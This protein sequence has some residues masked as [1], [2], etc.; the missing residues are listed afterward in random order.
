M[1]TLHCKECGA[2]LKI[3]GKKTVVCCE[4]C[5]IENTLPKMEDDKKLQRIERANQL[6]RS[7][8]FDKAAALYEEILNEDTTDAEIYWSLVLCRYGIEYVVDPYSQKHMP[9]VNRAQFTAIF[10]DENYKMALQYAEKEQKAVYESEAHDINEIQKQILAISQ[11]E[12]PFD[13]FIC[14]KETDE[15]GSRTP[16]SVLAQDLYYQLT[17]AGYKVF[18]ARITLEDKLGS[19][20]EPYIFAALNSSK[21]MIVL[22]SKTEYFNAVWVKNEWSRYLSLIKG[23]AKKTLVPAYRNMTPEQLPDELKHLQAVDMGKLGVMQDLL[24][25]IKKVLG[26]EQPKAEMRRA[27]AAV[28]SNA[29]NISQNEALL[30]RVFMFL[31]DGAWK[32][33]DA[34][35]EKVLDTDPE[36]ARAY[37]GKLMVKLHLNTEDHFNTLAGDISTDNNF[38][39]ALRFADEE[40][41]QKLTKYSEITVQ[42]FHLNQQRNIYR[43][44][45]QIEANANTLE[46]YQEAAR[47]YSSISSFQD[48]SAAAERCLAKGYEAAYKK[49]THRMETATTEAEYLDAITHFLPILT[50]KNAA[51]LRDRC[52]TL[53]EEAK[54]KAAEQAKI[55]LAQ[56]LAAEEERRKE[57]EQHAK[58]EKVSTA[59]E[60]IGGF[61]SKLF[62]WALSI[63]SIPCLVYAISVV[64][65]VFFADSIDAISVI[66]PLV[67]AGSLIVSAALV[68]LGR[69]LLTSDV[70]GDFLDS[71]WSFYAV[72]CKI[73]GIG[74]SLF[75]GICFYYT[76]TS[77]SAQPHLL[78]DQLCISFLILSAALCVWLVSRTHSDNLKD[79]FS[80]NLKLLFLNFRFLAFVPS[81]IAAIVFAFLAIA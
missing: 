26:D 28:S 67:S 42:N 6:R 27:P 41:A 53:A 10:D 31:E 21:I 15:R 33:A 52:L 56:R 43:R 14:Y 60:A 16:D 48:A 69:S 23:G 34:Y 19:A 32:D 76:I 49:G 37:L 18:F 81:V 12:D 74:G 50:Y 5:D 44:A 54:V 47:R 13:I 24:R 57:A 71:I 55:A 40:L 65:V 9:T 25:N 46:Q 11:N 7:K 73:V 66:T 64:V 59:L 2:P 22:G 68:I 51:E 78:F 45:A 39:K 4:Y 1:A 72:V 77:Y 61:F 38:Q 29:A 35:C 20:Y 17:D 8:E 75:A 79:S 36:N 63:L 3:D 80:K 58:K 70:D 30:K 62:G